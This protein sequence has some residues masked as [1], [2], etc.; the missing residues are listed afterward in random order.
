M[1]PESLSTLAV[2]NPGP[3]TAR[4][5]RIRIRQRV[6][7]AV[8]FLGWVHRGFGFICG[9]VFL[10]DHNRQGAKAGTGARK[11]KGRSSWRLR[12]P[13]TATQENGRRLRFSDQLEKL[14]GAYV[15]A[16]SIG[17]GANTAASASR[18]AAAD[19]LR[20]SSLSTTSAAL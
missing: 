20:L 2:M 7:I 15:A 1:P 8:E 13:L 3:S 5:R 9:R 16:A 17:A 6:H 18:S 11:G 12:E 4:K 14:A 19:V 10:T